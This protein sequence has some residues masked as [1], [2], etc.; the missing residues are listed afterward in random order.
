MSHFP[1]LNFIMCAQVSPLAFQAVA[2][3]AFNQ[4]TAAGNV[5]GPSAGG[6]SAAGRRALFLAPPLPVG[7]AGKI[8]WTNPAVLSSVI[9]LAQTLTSAQPSSLS[10]PSLAPGALASAITAMS[11]WASLATNA[12]D[13]RNLTALLQTSILAQGFLSTELNDLAAGRI[14]VQQFESQTGAGSL[15][16]L[17]ASSRVPEAF[18]QQQSPPVAA[19][20]G[21]SPPSSSSGLSSGAIAGIVVGTVVGVAAVVALAVIAFKKRRRGKRQ[22]EDK[23]AM[24]PDDRI[25]SHG[26]AE[27]FIALD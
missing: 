17:A 24:L 18:G 14:S 10:S 21:G 7:R 13:S 16:A 6:S 27:V 20:A 11:T 1:R 5:Y 22:G 8:D 15:S 23:G 4:Y 9:T 12:S 3:F 26:P 19:A 25:M 2:T